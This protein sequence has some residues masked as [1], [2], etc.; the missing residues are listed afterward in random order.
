[1]LKALELLRQRLNDLAEGAME[2]LRYSLGQKVLMLSPEEGVAAGTSKHC[3]SC[4]KDRSQSPVPGSAGDL[5]EDL[6]FC[7]SPH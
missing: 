3:I 5:L 6:R 2:N 4:F 1:M 7:A